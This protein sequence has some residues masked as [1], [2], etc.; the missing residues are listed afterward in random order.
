M[1][2]QAGKL[3]A[4]QMTS[5]MNGPTGAST[6][7]DM[8]QP[9]KP[10]RHEHRHRGTST[11]RERKREREVVQWAN[12]GDGHTGR[13]MLSSLEQESRPNNKIGP[14]HKGDTTKQL[15]SSACQTSAG[16]HTPGPP[17]REEI[18][19]NHVE[20]GCEQMCAAKR[21]PTTKTHAMAEGASF[22]APRADHRT[23]VT[24]RQHL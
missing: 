24:D 18:E 2:K 15:S 8:R 4:R 17:E 20:R 21:R 10:D 16:S 23:L 5:E 22:S 7:T 13:Y 12:Q 14:E 1:R 3:N 19:C 6:C 9:K 11:T